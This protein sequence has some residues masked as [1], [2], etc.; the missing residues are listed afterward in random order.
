VVR[1]QD[2]HYR[3]ILNSSLDAVV[4][5]DEAERISYVNP[6]AEELFG[7]MA[8]GLKGEAI[9]S[10]LP[11]GTFAASTADPSSTMEWTDGDG[12]RRVLNATTTELAAALGRFERKAHI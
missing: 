7:R 3:R 2:D 1:E 12:R 6:A 8:D 10:V 9:E 4:M 5:T 11:G